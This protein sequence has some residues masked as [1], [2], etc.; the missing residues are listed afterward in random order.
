MPGVRVRLS[1]DW[2]GALFVAGLSVVLAGCAS[3]PDWVPWHKPVQQADSRPTAPHG[4]RSEP[5]KP[6]AP[7]RSASKPKEPVK[8]AMIDPTVLVGLKRPA[9]AALLGKPSA[10]S[11]DEM[12]LV[13]S[14]VANGCA[15]KVYFY[16]D[17]KTA[18]FHVLKYTLANEDGKPLDKNAPCRRKLLAVRAQNAG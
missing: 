16:P 18:N 10:T 2:R 1:P 11:K 3:T 17:L 5:Q 12:S 8:V 4:P 6:K 14:Y 15:L 9:V 7:A 13:W